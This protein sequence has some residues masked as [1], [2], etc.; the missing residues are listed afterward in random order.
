MNISEEDIIEINKKMGFHVVN[1][2][3]LNFAYDR[4]IYNTKSKLGEIAV[5]F[6]G[7]ALGHPFSNG[8]KRT[9]FI[10]IIIILEE[11]IE[12]G[13]IKGYDDERLKNYMFHAIKNNTYN[14]NSLER[15]FSRCLIK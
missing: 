10:V 8:N 2:S 12:N 3:N 7:I 9:A 1:K 15:G 5:M 4:A 13:E 14:L 6:S 11:M